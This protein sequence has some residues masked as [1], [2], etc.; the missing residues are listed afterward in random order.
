MSHLNSIP[1]GNEINQLLDSVQ[2]KKSTLVAVFVVLL[3]LVITVMVTTSLKNLKIAEI[4]P[5]SGQG[6]GMDTKMTNYQASV[7]LENAVEKYLTLLEN[8]V[9]GSLYNDVTLKTHGNIT[10]MSE[11]E[12]ALDEK[13][14][15]GND[16]PGETGHTMVGHLRIRNIKEILF[17]VIRS[18]TEGDFAEFGVWRGGS[19][20]FAAGLFDILNERERM[21]HV[22]DAFGKLSSDVG[23]YGNNN[24]YLAVSQTQVKFN[25]WKYGLL[26]HRRVQFHQGLFQDTAPQFRRELDRNGRR[27]AVLRID[28]NFYDSYYDV[29][30]NL[31]DHVTKNGFVIFD[32]IK[33]HPDVQRAWNDFQK[34]R[35]LDIELTYIDDHSAYFRKEM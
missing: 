1:G 20:I 14:M 15:R 27:L 28:G 5:L 12:F 8:A 17:D 22:F 3:G 30:E 9:T 35:M 16:W 11:S 4:I 31:Y 29:L 10:D 2:R 32:D 6:I 25:F 18:Q 19:C 13:R 26:N 23:G 24:D 33:S 7:P 34:V 21:V